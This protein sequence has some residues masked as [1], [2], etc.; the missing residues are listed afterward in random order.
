MPSS[1]STYAGQGSSQLEQETVNG[2]YSGSVA[3][4]NAARESVDL[5]TSL[6]TNMAS[7]LNNA[8]STEFY[9]ALNTAF[10]GWRG[11]FE[12][13]Q[14]MTR[15]MMAGRLPEDVVNF[16]RQTSGERQQQ[17]ALASTARNLGLTSLQMQQQGFGNATNLF[18]LVKRSLTAPT[19]DVFGLASG[20]ESQLMGLNSMSLLSRSQLGLQMSEAA[21]A[22]SQFNQNMAENQRQFNAGTSER[23]SVRD[24][25]QG[26]WSAEFARMMDE[27]LWNRNW[28]NQ[29]FD[30]QRNMFDQSRISQQTNR[31]SFASGYDNRIGASNLAQSG[32]QAASGLITAGGESYGRSYTV[33]GSGTG[34]GDELFSGSIPTNLD[35]EDIPVDAEQMSYDELSDWLPSVE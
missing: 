28:N 19:A 24:I 27:T 7:N 26:Q 3:N 34:A 5:A 13:M 1:I 15:D 4:R 17:G 9:E 23:A 2:V 14:N 22:G 29:M 6:A 33:F 12:Q 8:A 21:R 30:W 10:P 35:N 25:A 11:T 16:I 18:D 31:S 32:N 20:L